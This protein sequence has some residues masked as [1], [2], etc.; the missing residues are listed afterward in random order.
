MV[1]MLDLDCREIVRTWRFDNVFFL[2]T[3]PWPDPYM[4]ALW[5]KATADYW[6]RGNLIILL[7]CDTLLVESATLDDYFEEDRIVVPY[8]SWEKR[9]S[10]E[11]FNLWP[12][13]V[14][15]STGLELKV[16]YMVTRP[17]IFTRSTF[18]GLRR[19]IEDHRRMPFYAAVYSEAPYDWHNYLAHPFTFCDLETLGLYAD[20]FESA[21]Y[22][23]KD[24][25]LMNR[26]ERFK[27]LWSHTEFTPE[28]KEELDKLLQGS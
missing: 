1:V 24:F 16:D 23:L 11:A 3:T 2:Y 27:D 10:P 28:L 7:D 9:N 22:I 21:K 20:R 4:H 6:T 12:G 18:A 19:L 13:V 14:K 5:A 8:L 26:P 17:W 15:K 25:S